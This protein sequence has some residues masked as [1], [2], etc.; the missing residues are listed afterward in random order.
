MAAKRKRTPRLLDFGNGRLVTVEQNRQLWETILE[1]AEKVNAERLARV[2]PLLV[3]LA[4]TVSS[5]SRDAILHLLDEAEAA[6]AMRRRLR[7]LGHDLEA[8]PRA[9]IRGAKP[10][11]VDAV[12]DF[13]FQRWAR[14]N[15]VP[16]A[17]VRNGKPVRPGDL[18]RVVAKRHGMT[19]LA[20]W[21]AIDRARKAGLVTVP[22][23]ARPAST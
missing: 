14:D 21:K 6:P 9:G 4:K 1:R 3:A 10:Q 2:R 12:N 19:A 11:A 18:L 7:E 20:L 5:D 17:P 16:G 23:P 22:L 13:A 8:A 15:P